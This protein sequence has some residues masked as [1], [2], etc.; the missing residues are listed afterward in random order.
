MPEQLSADGNAYSA[1]I[2]TDVEVEEADLAA[3]KAAQHLALLN[4]VAVA[5]SFLDSAIERLTD[6]EESDD[7]QEIERAKNKLTIKEEKLAS[8]KAALLAF[9]S[10]L[11]DN[12]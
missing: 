3:E 2:K 1:I 10:N 5:K 11:E 6:A 7:E 12:N 8:A 4:Q 9:E